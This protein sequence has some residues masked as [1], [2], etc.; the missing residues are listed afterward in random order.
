VMQINKPKC[1][2]RIFGDW[3]RSHQ[4]GRGAK[5]EYDGKHYC[6]THHPPEVKRRDEDRTK[7]YDE[8]YNEFR[9]KLRRR[10][11]EEH[12][13]KGLTTEHLETHKA[14][15]IETVY[16]DSYESIASM[17]LNGDD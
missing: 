8:H 1:E 17:A 2:A 5:Y 16:G 12:Y 13:C 6:K 11:A 4:C 3:G 9:E 14:P 15:E 7:K 10:A